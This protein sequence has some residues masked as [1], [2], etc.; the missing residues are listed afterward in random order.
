MG[1]EAAD[2]RRI[3]V[4]S[5]LTLAA[6][7]VLIHDNRAH[8]DEQRTKFAALAP[9]D[10][11]A[12]AGL[13]SRATTSTST[14]PTST[15]APTTVVS[16]LA[17]ATAEAT[18]SEA[19]A[20]TT[21]PPTT[22]APAPPTTRARVGAPKPKPKP[23]PTTTLAPAPAKKKKSAPSTTA[24]PTTTVAPSTTAPAPAISEP[25]GS[26]EDGKATFLG[27]DDA[28]WGPATC[29]HRTL[30]KG[31]VV[32]ITNLDN[33]RTATCVVRDR[34][35][36]AAGRIIDLDRD[37]FALLADPSVGVIPVRITW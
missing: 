26:F 29:A 36:F 20:T 9:R 23:A 3:V 30:P 31:T 22:E 14:P 15:T 16:T 12:A 1:F 10:L 37:V 8:G 4:A 35:P 11:A 27:Y 19:P 7:P 32:A 24:A 33:G 25:S 21:A 2:R 5:F 13:G 6:L 34:G 18:T 28:T 17:A